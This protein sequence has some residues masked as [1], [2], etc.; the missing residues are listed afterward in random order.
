MM[1]EDARDAVK[2]KAVEQAKIAEDKLEEPSRKAAFITRWL[3]SSSMF[4][5]FLMP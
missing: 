2:R 5:C 1:M 4:L 3:S